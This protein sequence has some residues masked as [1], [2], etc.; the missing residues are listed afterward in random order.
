MKRKGMAVKDHAKENRL[1]IKRMEREK[2]LEKELKEQ[3]PAK[4]F[5]LR[6]FADVPSVLEKELAKV[7]KIWCRYSDPCSRVNQVNVNS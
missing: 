6:Q 5:K 2:A 3:S 4:S 7:C 1:I